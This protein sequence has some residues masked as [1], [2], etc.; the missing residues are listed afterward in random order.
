[1]VNI[2]DI[3]CPYC[4]AKHF[5][6]MYSTSTLACV[7]TL[8][9]WKDGKLVEDKKPNPNTVTTR[10]R[11]CECGKEFEVNNVDFISSE[12]NSIPC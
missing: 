5:A 1:M 12:C 7:C 9:I 4:G 8:K 2:K 3:S 11:C 10:F 6:E